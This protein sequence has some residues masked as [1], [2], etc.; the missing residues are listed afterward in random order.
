VSESQRRGRTVGLA[1]AVVVAVLGLAGPAGAA[2]DH[3]KVKILDDCQPASFD[4]VLGAGACVGDGDTPF[5]DFIAEFTA[6]R[7]VA[8]WA[9]KPTRFELRSGGSITAV[10]RGGEFHTFTEVRH[11]GNACVGVLN[12]P[13]NAPSDFDCRLEATTGVKPGDKLT[14][15]GLK[16]GKHR[17]QC[18]IH[19]WMQTTVKVERRHHHGHGGDDD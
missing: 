13:T 16:P 18:L 9:F 15:W 19:P 5:G 7:S 2:P 1:A 10:N 12:T 14:V 11:F 4:A 6:N 8:A 3:R 17:F